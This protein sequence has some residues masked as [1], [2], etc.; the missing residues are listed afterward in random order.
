MISVCLATR[1]R[2]EK[3]RQCLKAILNNT[4]QH[5]EIIIIDQSDNSK[6]KNIVSQL[7]SKKI[8]YVKMTATGK[9][10]ALNLAIKKA[11]NELL[12]FTDD[13]C[14]VAKDWLKTIHDTYKKFPHVAGV[15]GN[16]LAYPTKKSG[17]WI[18]PATFQSTS[19]RFFSSPSIIHYQVLGQ[20][21]NMSLKKSI[22]MSIGL[23]KEWLG[24]GSVTK[25]GEESELIFRILIHKHI[26]MTNPHMLVR[27]NRWLSKNE[28]QFQESTYTRG[29]F[30]FFAYYI[31]TSYGWITVSMMWRR[32]KERFLIHL[33]CIRQTPST[34]TL[35]HTCYYML[36]ECISGAYG[37]GLGITK[38]IQGTI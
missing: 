34:Q 26:L 10:K 9:A 5:F 8:R 21:N 24:V 31:Y 27:H 4:F 38:R 29:L 17:V 37:V 35:V 33:Q 30:A 36:H 1:N 28:Y 3:L 20:G 22:L 7:Q 14:L 18:C 15:F 13:D 23:F 19:A 16:T 6:T 11:K 12:A 32:S 2:P 25:A